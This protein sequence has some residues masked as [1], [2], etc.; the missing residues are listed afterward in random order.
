VQVCAGDPDMLKIVE[1]AVGL[2]RAFEMRVVAEG[3]DN[4]TTLAMVRDAGCDIGQGDL[5]APS[6]ELQGVE[7]WM[8]RRDELAQ[9]LPRTVRKAAVP[10]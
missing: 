7:A 5:F 9:S 10:L 1:G 8:A 4:L 2:A 3:I 6:L